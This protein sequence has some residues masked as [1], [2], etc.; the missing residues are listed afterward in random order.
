MPK[1]T[2]TNPDGSVVEIEVGTCVHIGNHCRL[3]NGC[4]LGNY[5]R[6]GNG[7]R[8]G[9]YCRLGDDCTLGNHC[10]LGDGCT[11]GNGCRLGNYCRL[12]DDCML[13]NH[14]RLGNGCMLGNHCRLGDDCTQVLD[15]GYEERGHHRCAWTTGK[16]DV[17]MSVG[18]H[19]A[20]SLDKARR[21]WGSTTYADRSRG[22]A[23]LRLIDYIEA[24]AK[25]RGWL[26]A[27]A[28]H[29]TDEPVAAVEA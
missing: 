18:C 20:W 15:L 6:L 25:A 23:Y 19:F 16:G 2:H 7:C 21:H 1:R 29:P 9:N 4:T 26:D 5:C 8:L 24:E 13:G 3:G 14:C 11:L 27:A 12:G 17:L 10:T 22:D 28:V